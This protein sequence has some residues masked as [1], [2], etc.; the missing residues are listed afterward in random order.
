VLMGICRS[1]PQGASA[2]ARGGSVP[3]SGAD[4][5]AGKGGAV[6]PGPATWPG[7]GLGGDAAGWARPAVARRARQVAGRRAMTRIRISPVGPVPNRAK[8][9][10]SDRLQAGRWP[11]RSENGPRMIGSNQG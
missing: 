10:L 11:G 1:R 7:D 3:G 2:P 9:S 5:A 6:L 8:P 4:W